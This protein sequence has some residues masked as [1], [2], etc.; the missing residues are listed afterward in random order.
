MWSASYQTTRT[1]NLAGGVKSQT[2]PS[3]HAVSYTY[4]AAGRTSSFSGNLG[5]G[6]SRTYA[7][8]ITYSPFGGSSREQFGTDTP[9][10]HKSF[11]NIR[12]Q[13]FDTRLSS[14]NDTWDWNRGRLILYYSSNHVWGG[15][16]MDNNGNV[17]FAETWIPPE[18][19]TLD[20][21][22]TLSE[23]SYVYDS[24]NRLSSV[25]EQRIS[26]SNGWVWQP[27][28]K[29]SYDYDRYGNR[30]IKT[31]PADTSGTGINNLSF[32]IQPAT[33]RLYAPGDLALADTQ[34]R[35]R[36]DAAG[37]Q[38]KDTYTGQ[39]NATYDAENRIV[40][41]QDNLAGTSTYTYNADGQRTRRKIDNQETWQVYGL[42]GEL[43]AEYA[44]NSSAG[45]PQKEYGYRNGELLISAAG[46]NCGVG[47]QGTKSWGATNPA[48][49]HIVGHQEGSDWVTTV[50]GDS[51]GHL[52]YGPYDNSFGQ[53]H[54]SAKFLL[55]VDNTSGSD[56]V[57]TLDVVTASGT[58]ILVQRQIR[59]NEFS[60]ANQW[61]WFT[62]EFD[63][64]CFGMVE[65]RVYWHDTV[66]MRFNQV[67]ITG[68][69]SIG[70][71]VRWLVTD[72]LGTPRMIVDQTGTLGSI[73]R[74]DYLPFGEELL[75]PAG[76]RNAALGY[77]S[78]DG[79][80]QQFTA[81]E[82]DI[83]TGLDYFLARYYASMQGRFTS[84]DPFSIIQMRQSAPNDAKTHSAFMQFIGDPR[85]WNR[86]AYGINSPLVFTDKT[87]LDIMIIE[88]G[89]TKG[90]PIG[91]TAIAVTGR[92]VF[93]PGNGET[94]TRYDHKDKKNNISGGGVADYLNRESP[95]RDTTIYVVK[96]TPEQDAAIVNSMVEQAHSKRDISQDK[97]SL[98]LIDNCST[99]VNEAL[100]KAGGELVLP[101]DPP[102]AVQPGSAG[103]RAMLSGLPVTVISMP[104]GTNVSN[105]KDAEKQII[106]NFEPPDR[107]MKKPDK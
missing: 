2:Y 50:S 41:I 72:H 16:G 19:A 11:Y 25:T 12:G 10:Y 61:Q 8:N 91:H 74:H 70:A 105:L 45:N 79:V 95:R 3:G 89:P 84:P 92:G 64:P 39:G 24:L 106:E 18:N 87:G 28:F 52:S 9:V 20:Q 73:K 6:A 81:K 40:T 86:F 78:D 68:V 100:D 69:N 97:R 5:D 21:T 34:R 88:N 27:Q 17:M 23:Q 33:N 47:Y 76:G 55:Q 30:T 4:D 90:N 49:G 31:G 54:H 77:T 65:A 96:T 38:T 14:V 13:L 98:L 15:S 66:N 59:R 51:A 43:L 26:V 102:L 44:A 58:T 36:Y 60:A 7:N 67:T 107:P 75:A 93:S 82:R 94:T 104:Q 53:G 83:E 29:Q 101:I 46:R 48:L 103:A 42:D 80:R 22:Q 1:Y 57:A 85:R 56:V 63:N 35:I 37:N 71:K 32:E 99:R 62:L